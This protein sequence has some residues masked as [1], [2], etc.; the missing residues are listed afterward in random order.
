[1][2]PILRIGLRIDLERLAEFVELVD[3]GRAEIGAQRREDIADR[4]LQRLRAVA[5]DRD[6]TC[7]ADG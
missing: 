3:V 2:Q 4:D 6:A 1:M 7:G 5:V